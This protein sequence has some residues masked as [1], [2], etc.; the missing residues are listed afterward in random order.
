M[1]SMIS[2]QSRDHK[3]QIDGLA[4]ENNNIKDQLVKIHKDYG[5][6]GALE[7]LLEEDILKEIRNL[8]YSKCK[9]IDDLREEAMKKD[10]VIEQFERKANMFEVKHLSSQVESLKQT[11]HKLQDENLNLTQIVNKMSEK[12]T[13]LK[14]ELLFFNS[15][16]KKAMELLGRKNETIYGQKSLIELFQEK[17][18]G[19]S[20]FPI[21]DLKK[22]KLEIEE[23]LEKEN[24]YFVKQRLKREREDCSKRL[25]DFLNLQ[26]AKKVQNKN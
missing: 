14:Q 3:A 15:E 21:E 11:Q 4:A 19:A 9:L 20:S 18:S 12:N 24:D 13:K 1:R 23:R 7:S 25:S 2:Q 26:T 10:E 16:L 6:A 8:V 5:V 17:I 22:K